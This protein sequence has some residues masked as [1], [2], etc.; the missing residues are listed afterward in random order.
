MFRQYKEIFDRLENVVSYIQKVTLE[1]E[2]LI[3]SFDLSLGGLR[4]SMRLRRRSGGLLAWRNIAARGNKQRD[5]DLIHYQNDLERLP[6]TV[7]AELLQFE[8]KR[9]LLN[10]N[11]SLLQHESK[12]LNHALKKIE[13]NTRGL[14]ST[15]L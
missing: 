14:E 13:S 6:Q 4:L 3:E 7:K 12:Q 11:F 2:R 9:I 10:L 8:K 5:Y 1:R 15:A